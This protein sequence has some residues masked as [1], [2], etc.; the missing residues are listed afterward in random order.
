MLAVQEHYRLPESFPWYLTCLAA[1]AAV[2]AWAAI[3][4]LKIRPSKPSGRI[5]FFAAKVALGFVAILLVAQAVMPWVLLTTNW[6]M[7]ALAA[8]GALAVEGVTSLYSL[9]RRTVSRRA[10]GALAVLRALLALLVIALL[11]Q[12][13]F[14]LKLKDEL[15]RTIAILLDDSGSMHVSDPQMTGT[16]KARLAD[17]LPAE[18]AHRLYRL[19]DVKRSLLESQRAV[20]AQLDRVLASGDVTGLAARQKGL[21]RIREDLHNAAVEEQKRLDEQIAALSKPLEKSSGGAQ[22]QRDLSDVKAQL[23]SQVR[24][25]LAEVAGI[26]EPS[27]AASL[28]RDYD[29]LQSLLST[30]VKKLGEQGARLEPLGKAIDEAFYAGLPKDLKDSVDQLTSQPRWDLAR[31]VLLHRTQQEGEKQASDL[32]EQLRHKGYLVKTYK[33]ARK[34]DEFDFDEWRKNPQGPEASSRPVDVRDPSRQQTN[35]G[36]ALEHLASS[37]VAGGP[38]TAV[39]VFTDGRFSDGASARNA[40]RQLGSQKTPIKTVL[41]GSSVPPRD[42]AVI[43]VDVPTVVYAGDKIHFRIDLKL[44]GLG[45]QPGR[46]TVQRVDAEGKKTGKP[47]SEDFTVPAGTQSFDLTV[48]LSETDTEKPGLRQYVVEVST[49]AGKPWD[50]EVLAENNAYNV[51]VDVSDDRTRVLLVE[52]RPRWE[53]RYLKN[54]FSDRDPTVQVQYVL[55]EPDTVEGLKGRRIIPASAA[56]PYGEVEATGLPGHAEKKL[57]K[58][59]FIKEWKKFDLILLGDISPEMFKAEDLEALESFVGDRGGTLVVIAGPRY[60]PHAFAQTPL[61]RMLPVVFK[62]GA[63][64]VQSAAMGGPD[65]QERAMQSFRITLTPEG[66]RHI[67]MRQLDDAQDNWR[68]W[69]AMPTAHWRYPVED[70]KVA[71]SVLAYATEPLQDASAG[72]VEEKLSDKELDKRRQF[73]RHRSLITVQKY[74]GGQVLFMG[75]DQTWRLRYRVGDTYHHRLWG[76]VLRWATGDKLAAGTRLVRLGAKKIQ[77]QPGENVEVQAKILDAKYNP[78]SEADAKGV[79][80]RIFRHNEQVREMNMSPV[81]GSLDRFEADLGDIGQKYGPGEYRAELQ[82]PAVREILRT[83]GKQDPVAAHFRVAEKA[84]DEQKYIAPDPATV[85]ELA[86]ASSGS[87]IWPHELPAAAREFGPGL[88]IRIDHRQSTLWD[89]WFMLAMIIV[90]VT[91]E[92]LLRKQVGLA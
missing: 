72:K 31:H 39:L 42:A 41:F 88:E 50:H 43:S 17:L 22:V 13:V 51:S 16:E 44:D 1:L 29:K 58:E 35:G 52:G 65:G 73:E 57:S 56:R 78:L 76:Q 55:L 77:Y 75:F 79:T 37:P 63:R 7:W 2:A 8:G 12:P 6:P 68:L 62:P 90:T 49:L 18:A 53:F 89:S 26:T 82:S 3:H 87:V 59:D 10:G 83:E 85:E 24:D 33:F 67:I 64:Y 27:Q 4:T 84:Y 92:W 54:L 91:A 48:E 47:I 23:V 34:V 80:I 60:M 74:K 36:K 19:D 20:S 5:L 81:P 21:E 70:T 30:A 15:R 11:A 61:E 45:G 46:A 86:R 9:E 40:A 14:S 69:Q 66:R 32:V 28:G 71:A 38:L 25:R